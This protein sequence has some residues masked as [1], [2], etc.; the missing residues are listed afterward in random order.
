[1]QSAN[2]P[3]SIYSH[4]TATHATP[5][6][7]S[8]KRARAKAR[9]TLVRDDR[10]ALRTNRLDPIIEL[11]R[12]YREGREVGEPVSPLEKFNATLEAEVR[13][14]EAWTEGLEPKAKKDGSAIRQALELL[15]VFGRIT[16][17][18]FSTIPDEERTGLVTLLALEH[19]WCYAAAGTDREIFK[20]AI[21]RTGAR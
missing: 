11:L 14:L 9:L 20:I 10:P 17:L 12:T 15:R 13:E 1:M 2:A 21:G 6:T 3:A 5:K 7:R 8:A 18:D 19:R 16:A 4:L